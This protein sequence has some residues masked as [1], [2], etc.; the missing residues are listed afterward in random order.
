M[1]PREIRW[2]DNSLLSRGPDLEETTG[3]RDLQ[4]R[5][6]SRDDCNETINEQGEKII[7]CRDSDDQ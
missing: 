2:G 4:Q 5:K 3:Q 7:T 1:S 6:H